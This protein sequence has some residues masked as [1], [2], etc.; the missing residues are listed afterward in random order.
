[1]ASVGASSRKSLLFLV[2]CSGLAFCLWQSMAFAVHAARPTSGNVHSLASWG[3]TRSL[4]QRETSP[5]F[6][7]GPAYD[8]LGEEWVDM[9]KEYCE[10][11]YRKGDQRRQCQWQCETRDFVHPIPEP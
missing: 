8:S 10:L 9:C 4:A 6:G 5:L 3:A 7:T 1:M 11:K 2:L